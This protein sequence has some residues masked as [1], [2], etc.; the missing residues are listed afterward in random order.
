MRV[1]WSALAIALAI[2]VWEGSFDLFERIGLDA[3]DPLDRICLVVL[4]LSGADVI[5]RRAQRNEAI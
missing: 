1:L 5:A 2:L 3:F 4:V